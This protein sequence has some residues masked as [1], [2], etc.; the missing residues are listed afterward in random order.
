MIN[1]ICCTLIIAI[2]LSACG[3][4]K[5]QRTN[6]GLEYTIHFSGEGRKAAL[7]DILQLKFAYTTK[8]DSV[9]FSSIALT[10]SMI[11]EYTDNMP[12][13]QMKEALGMMGEGD[14]MTFIFAADS[15]FEKVFDAETPSTFA[16]NDIIKW[17]VKMVKLFSREEFKKTIEQRI[18]QI[19]RNEDNAIASYC[20]ANE[21][22]AEAT[23]TG[24]V[25][26]S[27]KDGTGK[28]PALGDTLVVK[29]TGRF[30]SG[31]I[32]DSSDD[33]TG[34]IRFI[35]GD[36]KM[37]DGWEEGFSYMKEG[38]VARFIIPSRLA[39]G[40]KGFGPVQPDTPLVY[41]VEL[42]KVYSGKGNS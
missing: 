14:S 1:K 38:G 7:G 17:K 16:D 4:N 8:L 31:Q 9:L 35:L 18:A 28:Q 34:S 41:D 6:S 11:L 39:Y 42:L 2:F 21:I 22:F 23:S 24:L 12:F 20:I 25:Y 33:G 29:Y 26:A 13:S 32:F 37:I 10:D 27:F 19:A 36:G 5:S 15:V 40:I 3:T 30:L